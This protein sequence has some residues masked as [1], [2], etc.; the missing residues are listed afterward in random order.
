MHLQSPNANYP[1]FLPILLSVLQKSPNNSSKKTALIAEEEYFQDD[2]LIN[3]LKPAAK[4]RKMDVDGYALTS[5]MTS[6]QETDSISPNH[7]SVE[8]RKG[9]ASKRIVIQSD[10]DGDSEMETLTSR[11]NQDS[12]VRCKIDCD[13]IVYSPERCSPVSSVMD[14][15]P[16]LQDL[17]GGSNNE[18]TIQETDSRD[19]TKNSVKSNSFIKKPSR[20]S[21]LTDFG[22]SVSQSALTSKRDKKNHGSMNMATQPHRSQHGVSTVSS[23]G[24]QFMSKAMRIKVQI[25]D[26]LLLVPVVDR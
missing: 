17:F 25:E 26:K 23:A 1:P 22:A 6:N 15:Y 2:W 16:V 20:Q 21:K 8:R 3:D 11:G 18:D 10:S 7:G 12:P 14:D 13:D 19:R 24:D 5:G 9:S 4:R